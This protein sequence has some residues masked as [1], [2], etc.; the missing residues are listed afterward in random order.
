MNPPNSLSPLSVARRAPLLLSL[1]LAVWLAGC[2]ESSAPVE[3]V[4]PAPA[5]APQSAPALADVIETTPT[6]VVGISYDPQIQATAGLQAALQQYAAQAR[7]ELDQALAELGNDAPRVP[8]ELSLAFEQ[9]VDSPKLKAI[10]ADG[11]LYTGGAHGAP[12][13]ARF[14]WLVD[15]DRRLAADEL[16]TGA[17]GWKVVAD[18]VEKTLLERMQA[19]LQE[20]RMEPGV[21]AEVM[22]NARRMIADG[23]MP[24]SANFS[25]FEPV[26]DA[27]GRITAIRFIFPPY[28]VGPY[29]DGVQSVDVPAEVVLPYVDRRHAALFAPVPAGN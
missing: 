13:L 1:S 18:H 27:G 23:T 24:D 28:Q 17:G 29:A 14:V 21:R 9:T 4:A 5:A 25:Q 19:R 7:Q 10:A 15:E 3:P 6:H 2:G 22:D 11:S 26:V 8:Y 20:D 16:V 12:L